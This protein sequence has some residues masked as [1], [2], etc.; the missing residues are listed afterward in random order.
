VL[1]GG[2]SA[3]IGTDKAF[4]K[5]G[6][7]TLIEQIL[8]K[9][10]RIGDDVIVVTNSPERYNHLGV[11]LVSDISPGKGA[12]G[13]IYSGLKAS[14]NEYSFV[15]ACDMPFLNV[16]LIRYMTL[17]ASGHDV[18]IPRVNGL[19]EPLHAIYSKRC[20]PSIE[21]LLEKDDLKIVRFFS[22][23]RVRYVEEEEI[24][25]LDPKHLS[26]FNIN[27][28][29]DLEKARKLDDEGKSNRTFR[30]KDRGFR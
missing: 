10:L 19:L 9:L 12:L 2:E 1:A 15:V 4:L 30:S 24:N 17:L 22:D 29:E 21:R 5:I 13:G 14:K 6:G 23:V 3:R 28:L 16:N 8:E 26:F 11:R 20:I 18:V 27:T 7:K 25:V